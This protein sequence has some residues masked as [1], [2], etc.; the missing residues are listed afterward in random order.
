MKSV[1]WSSIA[2]EKIACEFGRFG[3]VEIIES[4]AQLD[5]AL[6]GA[7]ALVMSNPVAYTAEVAG[8]LASARTLRWL[9]LLSAGYD[10]VTRFGAPSGIEIT[11]AGNSWSP[12]VAEH[13]MAL[14]T[15]LVRRLPECLFAQRQELWDRSIVPAMA[16]L[17]GRTL[18]I[19]GFGSVGHEIA[20]RA[21]AFGMRIV[22][23][24]R[25]ERC[26]SDADEMV[27]V[28]ALHRVLATADVIALA[29][30]LTPESH[31][32]IGEAELAACRR[33]ALLVNVARGGIVDSRALGASLESGRLGGAGI[34]VTD[35]EPLP[36]SHPLWQAPNLIIT[37]HV[38]GYGSALLEERLCR[39]V[40]ANVERYVAGKPL[41]ARVEGL[42]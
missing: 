30:P 29:L 25:T 23:V 28:T 11:T 26:D 37:P 8:L 35:P 22:G 14:M 17:E 27:T 21:R 3:E 7:E 12:I 6:R 24:S 5:C 10:G 34:D 32:L 42:A 39:L 33:G 16:S 15:A 13:A 18:V 40:R 9:Q 31:H 2:A 38:A 36:A 20:R 4:P 19:I 1:I 41:L